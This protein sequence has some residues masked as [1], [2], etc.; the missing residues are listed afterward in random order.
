M[1]LTRTHGNKIRI[2][3]GPRKGLYLSI[4]PAE[5]DGWRVEVWTGKREE[6]GGPHRG[7]YYYQ[8]TSTIS[9]EWFSNSE[10]RKAEARFRELKKVL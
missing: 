3:G 6:E 9:S 5:A 8:I 2:K 10:K 7:R 1:R 4:I